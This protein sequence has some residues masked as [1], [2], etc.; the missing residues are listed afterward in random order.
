MVEEEIPSSE[1]CMPRRPGN[2]IFPEVRNMSAGIN[3]CRKM[4]GTVSEV[5]SQAQQQEMNQTYSGI[6]GGYY[7]QCKYH[8]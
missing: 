5:K 4:K 7:Y 1:I 8:K 2:I 3:L 6:M